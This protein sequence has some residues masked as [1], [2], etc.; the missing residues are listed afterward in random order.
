ME[1][2]GLL[3][4][5]D[6]PLADLAPAVLC[7]VCLRVPARVKPF[8]DRWLMRA[9]GLHFPLY[10][11]IVVSRLVRPVEAGSL[12]PLCFDHKRMEVSH[13]DLGRI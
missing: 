5:F 11:S 2:H 7:D 1:A 13:E 6:L 3:V 8:L 4:V 10:E 12:S 9:G